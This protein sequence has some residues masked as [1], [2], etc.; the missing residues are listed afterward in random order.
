MAYEARTEQHPIG[1]LGQDGRP[2]RGPRRRDASLNRERILAAADRVVAERGTAGTME[3]I[4]VL[5]GVGK[6]TLYRNFSCRAEVASALLDERA[7]AV[8]TRVLDELGPQAGRDAADRLAAFLGIMLDFVADSPDLLV[9]A[10]ERRHEGEEPGPNLWQ[11]QVVRALLVEGAAGRPEIDVDHL[12]DAFLAL[13]RP[14]LL[15]HQMHAVGLDR[16]R[17]RASLGRLARAAL[18]AS[19]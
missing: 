3:E 1:V 16:E 11:R 9:L 10:D 6:G 8:Q 15:I 4:A 7:R 12:T 19:P 2:V 13:I 14:E 17:I 5:A 18:A